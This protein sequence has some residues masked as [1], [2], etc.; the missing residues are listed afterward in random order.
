MH[1]NILKKHCSGNDFGR[2]C[3]QVKNHDLTK[4]N[5]IALTLQLYILIKENIFY[6]KEIHKVTV[7]YTV[8][9]DCIGFSILAKKTG[10][11]NMIYSRLSLDL[12]ILDFFV[13]PAELGLIGMFILPSRTRQDQILISLARKHCR[14]KNEISHDSVFKHLY[15]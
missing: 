15:T 3:S 12:F 9:L 1:E 10:K 14:T 5:L 11:V 7:L 8:L 4:G 6:F 2:L 13:I